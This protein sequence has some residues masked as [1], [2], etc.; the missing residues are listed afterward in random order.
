MFTEQQIQHLAPK[1]SAFK[2]GKKLAVASKWENLNK[3]GRAIWG[4]IKGSGKNPYIVQIDIVNLAYKCTCPSRQFP[5]KHAIGLLLTQSINTSDF[6]ETEEPDYVE[7]W[8]NKR[9]QRAEKIT[10]EETELTE[11]ERE[12]R[13]ANKAKRQGDKLTLTMAGISELKLWL[14]DMIRIGILE[15]PNRPSSYFDNMMERMV[16]AKAPALAGWIRSLKNLPYKEQMLWQDQSLAIIGKLFLL[17]KSAENIDQFSASDQKAI[18]GLLGWTI[19]QKEMLGDSSTLTCRDQWLILGSNA[20]VLDD[21]TVHRYWL[22]GLSSTTNALIIRFQNKFTTVEQI[23]LVEGSTIEAELAFYPGLE[24]HR[25]FI[26]K[27]KETIHK[28]PQQ[29]VA[30]EDWKMYK[31]KQLQSLQ[32]NPWLNNNA[33]II[34]QINVIKDSTSLIAVDRN[35]DYLKVSEELDEDKISSLLLNALDRPVNISFVQKNDGILPLGLFIDQ[36]YQIL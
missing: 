17:I 19:T 8:I 34:N 4:S 32:K 36:N 20:E 24:P 1:E 9:A 6:I 5:C 27:Q 12:K 3:S 30:L 35:N 14:T 2:A 22:Y 29:P 28:L 23:P 15:L 18:K 7:E 21:L 13:T 33:G 25:A 26:K 31:N 16:D 11:E 10:K